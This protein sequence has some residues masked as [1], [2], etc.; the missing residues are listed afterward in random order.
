MT[1][2]VEIKAVSREAGSR[3][4]LAVYSRDPNVDAVGA[5]IGPRR[6]ARGQGG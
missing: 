6:R 1:A 4:K 2:P 3:T 5:C